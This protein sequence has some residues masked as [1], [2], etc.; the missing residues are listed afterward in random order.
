MS[1]SI[2]SLLN[3][4]LKHA[5]TFVPYY[6]ALLLKDVEDPQL[7][8]FPIINADIV[9]ASPE[10]FYHLDRFPDFV[11]TTGGT[12]SSGSSKFFLLNYDE[13]DLA[14]RTNLSLGEG[15]FF[16]PESF[17]GLVLNLTDMQHG[18]M[19]PPAHGQPVII[20][21]LEVGRHLPLVIRFLRE[22][23]VVKGIRYKFI[24]LFG[25]IEASD[26]LE[27]GWARLAAVRSPQAT[28]TESVHA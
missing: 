16:K 4:S 20:L 3:A 10:L 2:G 12:T 22:G 28:P 18:L 15:F 21:P 8:E 7:Q 17:H 5:I 11:L 13:A 19:L 6:G 14:F 27:G 1:V 23:L 24:E 9:S 25:S 26:F